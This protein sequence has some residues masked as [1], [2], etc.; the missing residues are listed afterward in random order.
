LSVNAAKDG[1]LLGFKKGRGC[2]GSHNRAARQA[3]AMRGFQAG[4]LAG[5][6]QGK[7]LCRYEGASPMAHSMGITISL[8]RTM[9]K[10]LRAANSIVRGSVRS[11]SIS[12]RKD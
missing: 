12:N 3:L 5:I 8:A 4:E 1:A 2:D 11:F 7:I 9:F 10:R 6:G